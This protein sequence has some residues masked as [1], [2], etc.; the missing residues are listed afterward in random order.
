MKIQKTKYGRAL[1]TRVTVPVE[2]GCI[3]LL[4]CGYVHQ[5]GSSPD[6]KTLGILWR[7]HHVSM[8]HY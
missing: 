3:T 8:I 2:L 6:P 1:S 5:D 4:V 7:L